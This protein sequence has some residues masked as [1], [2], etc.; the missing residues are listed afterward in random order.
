MTYAIVFGVVG[1]VIVVPAFLYLYRYLRP[2][3]RLLKDAKVV[4][5]YEKSGG[6]RTHERANL[7]LGIVSIWANVAALLLIS[8]VGLLLLG[9]QFSRPHSDEATYLSTPALEG[10]LRDRLSD[11]ATQKQQHKE[12][13]DAIHNALPAPPRHNEGGEPVESPGLKYSVERLEREHQVTAASIRGIIALVIVAGVLLGLW[14]LLKAFLVEG[15]L[16][17]MKIVE[18]LLLLGVSI[19]GGNNLKTEDSLFKSIDTF[20]R[21]DLHW[22]GDATPNKPV[23][24]EPQQVDI[25]LNLDLQTGNSPAPT[26]DCGEGDTFRIGPFDVGGTTLGETEMKKLE[27]LAETLAAPKSPGRIVAVMLIGSADKRPLKPKTAE[28]FSSNQGLAQARA[29]AVRRVLEPALARDKLPILE[30]YA[31]PAKTEAKLSIDDLASDRAVQVCV[32]W[33]PKPELR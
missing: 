24:S 31:G 27:K 14:I 22:G 23:P 10:L 1:L 8:I 28:D 2:L 25:H 17:T 21:L 11:Q 13:V 7:R 12:L 30:S 9:Q 20:F 32:F 15:K 6:S 33:S 26:M 16:P 3:S 19:F 4:R 18:G 29:K 5:P